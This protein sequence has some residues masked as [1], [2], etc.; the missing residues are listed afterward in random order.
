MLTRIRSAGWQLDMYMFIY[1]NGYLPIYK[2]ICH[3]EYTYRAYLIIYRR[4]SILTYMDI[5]IGWQGRHVH[6]LA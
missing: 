6:T 3:S 5:Q 1:I 2:H 4:V